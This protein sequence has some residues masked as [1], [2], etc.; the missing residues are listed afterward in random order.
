M[1]RFLG[2]FALLV[3][4]AT[5]AAAQHHHGFHHGGFG[6]GYRSSFGFSSGFPGF[7]GFGYRS[8]FGFAA[9]APGFHFSAYSRR[10]YSP[11]YSYRYVPFG[12][13]GFGNPFAFGFGNPFFFPQA[14]FVPPA[15]PVVIVL[16]VANNAPANGEPAANALP[17]TVRRGEYLVI[18]PKTTKATPKVDRVAPLPPRTVP[19]AFRFDMEKTGL[20]GATERSEIDPA[21]EAAR[22]MS[23]ARAAFREEDYGEAVELLD[24]ALAARPSPETH[25][26]KGQA[27][28]ASG[29]YA[30][31]VASIRAG[32]KLDP[33][34]PAALFAPRSPYGAPD[35]FE[36]HLG[37]LREALRAQPNEASLQFLLAYQL[38]FGGYRDEA[39]GRFRALNERLRDASAIAGF[40]K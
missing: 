22:L 38:W 14:A 33:E 27:L 13:F 6:F 1:R 3:L 8:S 36:R 21:A 30:E 5:P 16:P 18:T 35:R 25:F 19:V 40:L 4:A 24:R 9:G 20:P 34:R 32:L 39:R 12:G 28:F 26:L 37:E 10:F 11:F 17:A 15:P 31:A 29:Q 23:L 7:G 2:A